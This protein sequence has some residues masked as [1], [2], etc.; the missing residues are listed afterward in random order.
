[1]RARPTGVAMGLPETAQHRE[2]SRRQR[3]QWV[4][5]ALG[6]AHLYAHALGVD[7]GHRERQPFAQA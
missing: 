2:R 5:V 3:H 1:M 6:V 4:A 7:V